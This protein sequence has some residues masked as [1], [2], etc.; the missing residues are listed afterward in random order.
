MTDY[1]SAQLSTHGTFSLLTL[2]KVGP[3]VLLVQMSKVHHLELRDFSPAL[4]R[5]TGN[6]RY[7]GEAHALQETLPQREGHTSWGIKNVKMNI[8]VYL[9]D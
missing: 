8:H 9:Y 3:P 4:S 5:D 2:T 6:L 1:V 7:E